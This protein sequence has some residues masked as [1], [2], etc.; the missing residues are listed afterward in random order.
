[1]Q[2]PIKDAAFWNKGVPRKEKKMLRCILDPNDI[3][4]IIANITLQGDICLISNK[5][6]LLSTQSGISFL[7]TKERWRRGK[8]GV[9]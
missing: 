6:K 3:D 1:M 8:N 7:L 9:A 2:I 4:I 5:E